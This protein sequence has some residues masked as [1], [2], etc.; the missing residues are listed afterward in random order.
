ML[1]EHLDD[2]AIGDAVVQVVAEFPGEALEGG[3][4]LFIRRVADDGGD[5]GDVG[6]GDAGDVICPVFPVVP[7]AAFFDDLGVKGA[8]QFADIEGEFGLGLDDRAPRLR[9]W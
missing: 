9:Q 2:F 3:D 6:L 7:V 1:G 5:A 4:F 8:L